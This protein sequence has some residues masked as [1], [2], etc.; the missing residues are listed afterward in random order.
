M[1]HL[2]NSPEVIHRLYVTHIHFRSNQIHCVAPPTHCTD[3]RS[4]LSPARNLNFSS[5]NLPESVKTPPTEGILLQQLVQSHNKRETLICNYT[6]YVYYCITETRQYLLYY[7]DLF[8]RD[9]KPI[10]FKV[11]WL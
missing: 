9:L 3:C 2:L 7:F 10:S 6:A 1:G 5:L 4:V 11:L 8:R